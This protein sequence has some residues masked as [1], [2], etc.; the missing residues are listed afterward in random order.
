MKTYKFGNE[1]VKH[2]FCGNCGSSLFILV[3]G[4]EGSEGFVS[5]NVSLVFCFFSF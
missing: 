5:A 3:D 4:K 2:M 1:A